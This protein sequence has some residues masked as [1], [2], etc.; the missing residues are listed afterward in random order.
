MAATTKRPKGEEE[1]CKG[2]NWTVPRT[3]KF[4]RHFSSFSKMNA[5]LNGLEAT[6]YKIGMIDWVNSVAEV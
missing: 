4:A 2:H 3:G 6:E 1:R 5:W